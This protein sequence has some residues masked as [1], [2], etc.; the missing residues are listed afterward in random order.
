M[1]IFGLKLVLKS[2][3]EFIILKLNEPFQSCCCPVQN[4][5]KGELSWQ[6]SRKHTDQF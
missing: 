1:T 6:V 5:K 4:K 2:G 3:L